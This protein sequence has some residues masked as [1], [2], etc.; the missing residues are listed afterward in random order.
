MT[1]DGVLLVFHDNKID[2]KVI[3]YT[4]KKEFDYYRLPNNETNK[5]ISFFGIFEKSGSV[6]SI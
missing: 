4:N 5:S 1:A 2:G 3:N 6:F